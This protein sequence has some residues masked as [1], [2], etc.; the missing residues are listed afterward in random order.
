MTSSSQKCKISTKLLLY[1]NQIFPWFG[2]R[3]DD[4]PKVL[5]YRQ[6]P[7]NIFLL[8][9]CPIKTKVSEAQSN[10]FVFKETLV[11][12][13]ICTSTVWIELRS[14]T[15]ATHCD[16]VRFLSYVFAITQSDTRNRVTAVSISFNPVVSN[17]LFLYPLKTSENRKVFWCFQGIE[18]GCIRN[19]W[20]N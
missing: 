4:R 11:C 14:T 16:T 18:K 8:R 10:Y 5:T 3:F 12:S 7:Q 15:T 2:T 17:T 1:C 13:Q 9:D 20:V 19:K 6:I